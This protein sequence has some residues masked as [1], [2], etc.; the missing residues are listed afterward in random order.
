MSHYYPPT[1]K[2]LRYLVALG[3][4]LHFGKAAE[5]CHVTQSS[6]SA[7]IQELETLLGAQLVERSKRS[8]MLTPLGQEINDRA[9]RILGDVDDLMALAATASNPKAGRVR[10]G[11]IPTI[12]PFLLPRIMPAIRQ[13]LP[14]MELLLVEEKSAILCEQ[15]KAGALDLVL[16]ALP[17]PC[18]DMVEL[19]LFQDNFVAA[20]PADSAPSGPIDVR[21]LAKARLLLLNEG[22]CLRDHALDACQLR[23]KAGSDTMGATSLHTLI[24]MVA[25]GHGV[26]LLPEMAVAS[27][28]AN[29]PDI[30]LCPFK[31]TP[32]ART[33]G[34]IWRRTNPRTDS[35]KMLGEVI[36]TC[37]T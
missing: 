31:G 21:A 11:I 37:L 4:E 30:I 34:L 36:V 3:R 12:A 22:H 28:F 2:Q 26:T 15:L 20:Y 25:S 17:Y 9:V 16:Y 13:Q 5:I 29:Q 1:L 19:P 6:L 18:G 32:P 14:D 35:F 7:G 27:G 24:Q 23:D 8:V 33:I 10:L